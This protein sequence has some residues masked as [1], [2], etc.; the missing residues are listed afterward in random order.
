[1]SF[2]GLGG[3]GS[4]PASSASTGSSPMNDRK[5]A[6][7]ERVKRE[8]DLAG[9]QELIQKM[10]ECCYAKCL[11]KPGSTFTSGDQV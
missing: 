3:G 6:V 9:A 11:P 7:M 2:L 8:M 10:T 5:S 1:M 4:T